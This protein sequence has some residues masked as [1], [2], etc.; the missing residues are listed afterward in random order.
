M[1]LKITNVGTVEDINDREDLFL[2]N[3][4]ID[5]DHIKRYLGDTQELYDF[6]CFFLKVEYGRYT[7][8]YATDGIPWLWRTLWKIEQ[9]EEL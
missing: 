3:V 6:N 4:D 5:V 9:V 8:I 7:E 1:K 2:C